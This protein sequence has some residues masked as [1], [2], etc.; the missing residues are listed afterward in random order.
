MFGTLATDVDGLGVR[1]TKTLSSTSCAQ[2][3][4]VVRVVLALS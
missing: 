2:W 3:E 1:F 4:L